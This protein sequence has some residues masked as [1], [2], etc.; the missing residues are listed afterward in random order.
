[1]KWFANNLIENYKDTPL[2]ATALVNNT[3]KTKS[4]KEKLTA[5]NNNLS[6]FQRS[7]ESLI[8]ALD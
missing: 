7:N 8:K 1:L 4:F 2:S 6:L 5:N 3:L